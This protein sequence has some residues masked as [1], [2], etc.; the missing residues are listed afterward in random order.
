MFDTLI[1]PTR[2]EYVTKKV[3][4]KR[5]P[6][7]ESVR[8]LKEFE[9]AARDK[10]E[11]TYRLDFNGFKCLVQAYTDCMNQ[12]EVHEI[13][14][15]FNGSKQRCVIRFGLH[16]NKDDW[17]KKVLKELSESIA[18]NLLREFKVY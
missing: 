2:T 11:K 14:Y 17:G 3:I 8:L 12:E 6:T 1:A 16:E 13:H 18:L 4:E 9:E 5:A 7:D 15:D 10:I